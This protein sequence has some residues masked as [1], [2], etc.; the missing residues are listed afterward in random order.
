[1]KRDSS[2]CE[3]FIKN[4]Y[5]PTLKS[6]LSFL[7]PLKKLWKNLDVK[8]D[9]VYVPLKLELEKEEKFADFNDWIAQ[10]TKYPYVLVWGD[11]GSGKSTLIQATIVNLIEKFQDHR[12]IPLF[13]QARNWQ[14]GQRFED[15]LMSEVDSVVE[16]A[17][18]AI[19]NNCEDY[20]LFLFLDGLDELPDGFDISTA[21]EK[22]FESEITKRF[23]KTIVTAR[24][25]REG[26]RFFK[27]EYHV[28]GLE[29]L[30]RGNIEALFNKWLDVIRSLG[31]SIQEE[32]VK[33]LQTLLVENEILSRL[34]SN[35]LL[36]SLS[37][38]WFLTADVDVEQSFKTLMDEVMEKLFK[39]WDEIRG[40]KIERRYALEKYFDTFERLALAELEGAKV[41]IASEVQK[42]G[43]YVLDPSIAEELEKRGVFVRFEDGQFKFVNELFRDYFAA[44][45]MSRDPANYARYFA[46]K[47]FDLNWR[48]P[49]KMTFYFLLGSFYEATQ[50]LNLFLETYNPFDEI[51]FLRLKNVIDYLLDYL[52]ALQRNEVKKV[53]PGGTT[54]AMV[55]GQKKE[56]EVE[57]AS[58]LFERISLRFQKVYSQLMEL[59]NPPLPQRIHDLEELKNEYDK[60][61]KFYG[62]ICGLLAFE[63]GERKRESEEVRG[64]RIA[65]LP[66]GRG[67]EP[68]EVVTIEITELKELLKSL[69]AAKNK[70]EVRKDER[71]QRFYREGVKIRLSGE[72]SP[73]EISEIFDIASEPLDAIMDLGKK[74]KQATG[75]APDEILN[76]IREQEENVIEIQYLF[77]RVVSDRRELIPTKFMDKLI[78][79]MEFAEDTS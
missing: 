39:T 42:E 13:A 25:R 36:F 50:F 59:W 55:G 15:F 64:F 71:W 26:N 76:K 19:L 3:R 4:D 70:E 67:G 49:F 78:E 53:S 17:F 16:D 72:P 68:E 61:Q 22:F 51:L 12:I 6:K 23:S 40:V 56:N 1:M 54:T 5:F 2:L 11:P 24:S 48:V 41:K 66:T 69:F 30:S 37:F 31:V 34:S 62:E 27:D 29:S 47:L 38:L 8:L 73:D 18:E 20:D 33:K 28:I 63:K 58:E 32:T 21:S 57:K 14:K 60:I 46:L 79:T 35:P 43:K 44:R 10:K 65:K 52:S 75:S 7:E 9:Q 74:K 77:S 45:Y